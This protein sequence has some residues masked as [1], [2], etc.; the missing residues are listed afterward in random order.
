MP[1]NAT[2]ND[3]LSIITIITPDW[4]TLISSYVDFV[5]ADLIMRPWRSMILYWLSDFDSIYIVLLYDHTFTLSPLLSI[6]D[7]GVEWF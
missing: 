3:L 1:Y 7:T 4:L 5:V 6:D 2:L